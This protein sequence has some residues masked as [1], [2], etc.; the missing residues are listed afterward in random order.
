[1]DQSAWPAAV[2]VVAESYAMHHLVEA[3][4]ARH[5]ERI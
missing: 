4:V 5:L 3:G 2:K 1:M